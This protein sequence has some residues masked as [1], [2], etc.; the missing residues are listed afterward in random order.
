MML[1]S[2]GCKK[3]YAPSIISSN[4]S[5]LVVEGVINSGTD[6]TYIK[7]TRTVK[8]SN[9]AAPAP[10]LGAI[11]T[12]EGDNNNSYPIS[13][14]GNGIYSSA[15]LNLTIG[16]NY[17]LRIKTTNNKEYVSDFVPARD[18]PDID[19]LNYKVQ[20]NGVEIYVNSHDPKNSTR[21][22]RWD[23]DETFEYV[24][25]IRSFYKIGDDGL[26]TY[27]SAYND[28]D[29]IY[30]CYKF[31]Q[32][33]Q[34]LLGSSAK[35]AQDVIAQQPVDFVAANS[36]KISLVYSILLRQY[37][38]TSDAFNYW[39]VLKKNTEQLGTIFDAQ[40]ST[41]QGN[42]HCITNAN[43]P[44]VGYI[45]VSGV[46]TKRIILDHYYLNLYTTN[47]PPTDGDACMAEY[48]PIEPAE[49]FKTRLQHVL[50]TG[51]STLVNEVSQLGTGAL[52]GYTYAPTEC[53]DCR[54]VAP[55]GNNLVPVYWPYQ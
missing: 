52:I 50:F 43:E 7:L 46:K 24:S 31:G 22:Y 12:V 38:L 37:A 3:P 32:S 18:T 6:S 9:S 20:N 30:Y 16:A 29:N 27:R 40:P 21:Y 28:S 1:A 49:T 34:V 45:S 41:I 44:V 26:P 51:D 8:L 25:R 10:E 55:F 4:N 23:F 2:V 13:E 47:P 15:A 14:A 48:I 39:Q 54:K 33:H 11:V 42:I 53:V 35:L 5:Y 19:S 36:G 17:R